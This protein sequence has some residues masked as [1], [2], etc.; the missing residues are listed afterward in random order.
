MA[1]AR[2]RAN[3][4]IVPTLEDKCVTIERSI[5]QPSPH[6]NPIYMESLGADNRH[7]DFGYLSDSNLTPSDSNGSD[8]S[9]KTDL[10]DHELD[11][12]LT[13]RIWP[14]FSLRISRA[15]WSGPEERDSGGG[16]RQE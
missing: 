9:K 15:R 2:C 8:T 5:N 11:V 4:R 13:R 14:S 3:K 1:P 6:T 10:E 12:G 7:T 16:F